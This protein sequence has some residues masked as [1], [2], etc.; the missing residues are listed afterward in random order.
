MSLVSGSQFVAC[1]RLPVCRLFQAPSVSLVTGSQFV[2]GFRLPVCLL[3]QAPS[4]SLCLSM[5]DIHSDAQ[6]CGNVLLELSDHLSRYLR[7]VA[8][9]VKN[10]EVDY[11]LVIRFV[12][13]N[14]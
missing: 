14:A 4:V 1:Y 3:F 2:A 11:T 9:G 6:Q 8:P 7:P 13:A 12:N 5:L 10:P